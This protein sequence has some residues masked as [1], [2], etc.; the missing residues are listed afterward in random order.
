MQIL[1]QYALNVDGSYAWFAK[2]CEL[3]F[4]SVISQLEGV[5]VQRSKEDIHTACFRCKGQLYMVCMHNRYWESRALWQF[6]VS[7]EDFSKTLA[8]F[9]SQAASQVWYTKADS[10]AACF[11]RPARALDGL[12]A[13]ISDWNVLATVSADSQKPPGQLMC[14]AGKATYSPFHSFLQRYF[15]C[16]NSS[17]M[18]WT[19][20]AAMHDLQ[21]TVNCTLCQSFPNL[22]ESMYNDQRKTFI[23]HVSDAKGSSGWSA[24]TTGTERVV[25]SDNLL[26]LQRIFPRH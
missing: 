26:Y 18:L 12:H 2:N 9:V 22:K 4:V 7:A 16:R 13:Q 17:S 11:Q 20:M 5:H 3:Y 1:K 10:Y 25:L 15:K 23:Q 21:R 24:C 6:I 19:L 14:P 8:M